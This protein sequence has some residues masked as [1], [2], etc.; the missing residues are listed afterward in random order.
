MSPSDET[1]IE[2]H[3]RQVLLLGLYASAGA[4][5]AGLI[6]SLSGVALGDSVIRFG[7]A[8]L[9]A[10][11]IARLT[12]SFATGMRRRDHLLTWAAALVLA[13]MVVSLLLHGT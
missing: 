7:L 3:V 5:A 9:V 8:L 10:S 1:G 2:R 12:A 6:L 11:P 13:A 4:A